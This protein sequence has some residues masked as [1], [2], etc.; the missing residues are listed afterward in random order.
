MLKEIALTVSKELPEAPLFTIHDSVLTTGK[1]KD[2]VK[3]IMTEIYRKH[4]GFYPA[5]EDKDL[6]PLS[7]VVDMGKYCSRKLEEAKLPMWQ[8]D[9][10]GYLKS[11]HK[12]LPFPK[13]NEELT[14]H[15]FSI[16]H[17][18]PFAWI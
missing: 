14:N 7:A 16:S 8:N 17:Y 10:T 15:I 18:D 1:Y 12:R 2:Q 13:L 3:Q 6:E 4:L 9:V 5:V 11:A